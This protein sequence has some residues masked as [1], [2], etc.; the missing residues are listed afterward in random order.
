MR[1]P[2]FVQFGNVYLNPINV[3]H[4]RS[5]PGQLIVFLLGQEDPLTFDYASEKQLQSD[6][7]DLIAGVDDRFFPFSEISVR[8]QRVFADAGANTMD[9]V[10]RFGRIRLIRRKN[11]GKGTVEQVDNVMRTLGREMDWINS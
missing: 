3:T 6:L 10:L 5:V 4:A 8:A 7:V 2:H 11:I 9:D 1:T